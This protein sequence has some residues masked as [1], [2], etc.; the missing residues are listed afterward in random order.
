MVRKKGKLL[1]NGVV[2]NPHPHPP[3][4]H[5]PFALFYGQDGRINL[6]TFFMHRYPKDNISKFVRSEDL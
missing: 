5:P 6:N 3:P 1:L 2:A 4:Q